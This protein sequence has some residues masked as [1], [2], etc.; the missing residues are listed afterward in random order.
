MPP[1]VPE[2]SG[3]ERRP[4]L[5]RLTKAALDLVFPIHCT[6]CGRE[7]EIICDQCDI[8]LARLAPPWCLICAAPGVEGVCRWC[9]QHPRG[10]KS[11]RSLYRFQG[12]IRDA[13]HALKY[14]GVRAAAERLGHLMAGYLERNPVPADVLIPV[15]LHRRRLRSRG[16]NQSAL[17]AREISKLTGLPVQDD[18]LLRVGNSPPQVEILGRDERRNNVSGNFACRNDAT[19]LTPLLID[20]VATTGS[21][22]SECAS[23][24]RRGGAD[25]VYA[26]TLARDE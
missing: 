20:D 8:G 19:S 26:L 23:V 25:T 5:S 24:L 11:L 9:I 15:P 12:P 6:G 10:F 22:L 2:Y 17:L 1:P 21:T 14:R 7:G 4:V 13:V 18:L 3:S 16:Y